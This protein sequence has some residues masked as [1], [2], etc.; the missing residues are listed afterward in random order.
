MNSRKLDQIV[1]AN[2]PSPDIQNLE[3]EPEIIEPE[4]SDFDE[5]SQNFVLNMPRCNQIHDN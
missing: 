5:L 3:D 1:K 4:F 2:P